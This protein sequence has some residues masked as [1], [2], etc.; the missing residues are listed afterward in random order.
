MKAGELFQKQDAILIHAENFYLANGVPFNMGL[1]SIA[2]VL[3]ENK[4]KVLCMNPHQVFVT[5]NDE[6]KR[7]I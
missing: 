2:T 5:K 6:L 4:Y 3:T 7:L 1:L